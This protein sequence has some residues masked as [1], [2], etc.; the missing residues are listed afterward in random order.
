MVFSGIQLLEH[1]LLMAVILTEAAAG[2]IK[3]YREAQKVEEGA[4]L[5]MGVAGGGCSGLQY[6]LG[7]DTNFDSQ[8]DA[9]YEEHGVTVVTTKKMALHLDGTTIDFL[10]G[11]MGRGFSID[12]PNVPRGGGC[13]GCGHR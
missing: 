3:R 4:V 10:D 1:K 6:T 7:F 11:P 2:E 13:P 9:R 12:N 5:R 8:V